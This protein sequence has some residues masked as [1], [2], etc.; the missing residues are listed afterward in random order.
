MTF[1]EAKIQFIGSIHSELKSLEDCPKQESEEAP[2]ATIEIYSAYLDGIKDL[3]AGSKIILFTWFHQADRNE[4]ICHPRDNRNAPLKGV[5][6]TRSPNR[7]NPIGMHVVE[8]LEI[9][10]GDSIRVSNLEAL[11]RTPIIDIKPVI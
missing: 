8:I 2:S 11:D 1:M 6:S 3:R 9:V 5:F 4:L 7:P 10:N